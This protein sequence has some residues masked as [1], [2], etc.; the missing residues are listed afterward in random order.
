MDKDSITVLVSDIEMQ[1]A[2]IEKVFDEMEN[3]AKGLKPDD[4]V[5]LESVAYQIHNLYNAVEDLLQTVAA[6]FENQISDT[7]RWHTVLLHRMTQ[8]IEGIRPAFL[9]EECYRL[10]NGLRG[11]RHFFRHAYSVPIEYDQLQVNLRRARQ[12]RPCLRRDVD[13]FLEQIQPAS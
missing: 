1:M 13:H 11:F 12:L 2:L 10:L 6:H 5:R 3:R 4:R 8:E 7:A 9:S